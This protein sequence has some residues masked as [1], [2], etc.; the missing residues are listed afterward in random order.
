MAVERVFVGWSQP[1]LEATVAYLAG[2]FRSDDGLDLDGV[3]LAVPGRRAGRRLMELL[4]QWSDQCGVRLAP[5]RIVTVG[6][7]PELLYQARR[8]FADEL[9]QRLA[10][11]AALRA[12]GAEERAA[13][14]PH[15]PAEE[16]QA[17]WWALGSL[18][19][20]VHRE[21]AAERLDFADVARRIGRIAGRE[22]AARWKA[23][24]AVQQRYL[25]TLD[26]LGLWDRQTARLYAIR[27]GECA[28]H[29]P[30]V[31]VGTVDLNRSQRAMLDELEGQV[32]TLV[33]APRS[34]A[35]RFDGHGCVRP[36][37]WADAE[38][39]LEDEGIEVVD[40]P[41]D[42]A[43][44][45]VRALASLEARYA[46]E[47][48]TVGVP[49]ERLVPYLVHQLEQCGVAA[50]YGP[51]VPVSQSPPCRL[52]EAVAHY[53]DTRSYHALAALVRHPAV[54]DW[55]EAQGLS[56]DWLTRLDAYYTRHLPVVAAGG[57][58]DSA[59]A[60]SIEP[61]IEAVDRLV[62]DFLGPAAALDRWGEPIV[63]LLVGL[64]GG[65]ALDTTS[66][67][68]RS[69]LVACEAVREVLESH[70][71]IPEALVPQV[72]GPEAIRLVLGQLGASTIPALPNP[73][74][75]E[76]LGWL[77]LPWDDAPVLIV[78]G[79]NEGIVPQSRNADLFLPNRLRR[80]LG[81][82][83]NQ[84]RYAR[85]A[86][87]LSL[88]ANS[89]R[90][91]HLIAGRR[92]PDGEPLCPSRL[93]FAAPPEKTAQRVLRFFRPEGQPL[94][95]ITVAGSLRAGQ[96]QSAFEPPPPTPLPGPV[97]SMTVTEF[98]DYLACP[99]RYYLRHRL[100]LAALD[101]AARE[102]DRADFG[103]LVHEVLDRFAKGPVVESTDADRIMGFLNEALD[104]VV[105]QRY[106]RHVRAAVRIQVEQAR[107]RLRAFARWQA[108]WAAQGWR[109][110]MAE[111]RFS[112]GRAKLVVDGQP[113]Y[114]RGR[115]DR[116]D[117]HRETGRRIVLDY[118]TS[119]TP[120][121]PDKVHRSQGEWKDL[122]LPLYRH[123]VAGLGITGPVGL[124]YIVLP[125][126][127]SKVA[128]RLAEWTEEDLAEADRVAEDVVRR[129]R[130]G[131]FWPPAAGPLLF[132]EEFAAICQDGLL[133]AAAAPVDREGS[134]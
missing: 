1:A 93:L 72:Q 24:A 18:V 3:V 57:T 54:E 128:E 47:Q 66:A 89:G 75:V 121:D 30:L 70:T 124:G 4:V 105:E 100:K 83:D 102:L 62:A 65:A 122:Q 6:Q 26:E 22:E 84:R 67:A 40:A 31:L 76:L 69:L 56:G 113:M 60:R 33:F 87:A 49:D 50:R 114:L 16:D 46:A 35:D 39:P 63:R 77:E 44:A 11:A 117:V 112:E 42:Q 104:E 94:G 74:A 123:L 36:E 41:A 15:P 86:Y 129:V 2:R 61:L 51:G 12:A 52:L 21:L 88:M 99:Y 43:V 78:T 8:P 98:R 118:K 96:K 107:A 132:F 92:T 68:D 34:L 64:F 82:E 131:D 27:H 126:D 7:L 116:I 71:G 28:A 125:K 130:A 127:T 48:I 108:G 106:G 91:L 29:F 90:R 73:A 55:L 97:T 9:T 79:M 37:A 17:A 110:E 59:E 45:A 101:D 20:R 32:T 58:G 53:A 95:R 23:L 19:G 38:I 14:L 10:W 81:I 115:V 109:I 134:T 5:P 25:R 119:D 103:S 120:R 85:D 80:E 111:Q 133:S 13:L